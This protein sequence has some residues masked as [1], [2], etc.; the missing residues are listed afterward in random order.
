MFVPEMSSLT[1]V[2]LSSH[3]ESKTIP[4]P[5]I[6][7]QFLFL[8]GILKMLLG[9]GFEPKISSIHH[10]RYAP[11]NLQQLMNINTNHLQLI[12]E[13]RRVEVGEK[14]YGASLREYFLKCRQHQ[15]VWPIV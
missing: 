5:M 1:T 10:H 11:K 12:L 4:P 8:W 2:C 3:A 14:A 7:R 13:L 9:L 15:S 6:L